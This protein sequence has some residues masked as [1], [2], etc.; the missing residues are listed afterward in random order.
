MY[1]IPDNCDAYLWCFD[2]MLRT[3]LLNV[4]LFITSMY[5]A[6]VCSYCILS[7]MAS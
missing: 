5:V 1:L 4:F 7:L 3:S 2:G 6:L